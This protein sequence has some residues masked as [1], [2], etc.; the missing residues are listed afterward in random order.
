MCIEI[1]HIFLDKHFERQE[2]IRVA[3][4]D[5]IEKVDNEIGEMLDEVQEAFNKL[6]SKYNQEMSFKDY[7]R[8]ER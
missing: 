1:D 2:N 8:D 4:E 6:A 5:F 7:I 3:Y